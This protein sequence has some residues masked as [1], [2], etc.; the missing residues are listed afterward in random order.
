MRV[1]AGQCLHVDGHGPE[2]RRRAQR[3]VRDRWRPAEWPVALRD[4]AIAQLLEPKPGAREH[5]AHEAH[6]LEVAGGSAEEIARLAVLR[7]RLRVRSGQDGRLV[8]A[9][10]HHRIGVGGGGRIG[11]R[12]AEE[13]A[14][15]AGALVGR[16]EGCA[17]GVE[18]G[19]VLD[20]AVG[21]VGELVGLEAADRQRV[22]ARPVRE[23][24][25]GDAGEAR[26]QVLGAAADL[27][28]GLGHAVGVGASTASFTAPVR[29]AYWATAVRA[30]PMWR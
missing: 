12:E 27:A 14:L 9:A 15:E 23:R 10:R 4:G 6:G 29:A 18:E 7:V 20:V 26:G 11:G 24:G 5:P 16:D 22:D 1:A 8:R 30:R 25:G 28:E 21:V 2:D 19:L 17:R 3:E 13:V